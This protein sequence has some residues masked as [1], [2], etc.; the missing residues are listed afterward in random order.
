MKKTLLFL[1]II[2]CLNANAKNKFHSVNDPRIGI[3]MVVEDGIAKIKVKNLGDEELTNISIFSSSPDEVYLDAYVESLQVGEETAVIEVEISF[4]Y[5]YCALSFFAITEAET[6][7]GSFISDIS[8]DPGSFSNPNYTDFY[9]LDAPTNVYFYDFMYGWQSGEY[10]DLNNNSIVDVGDVINYTYTIYT[11]FNMGYELLTVTD[12]NASVTISGNTATGIHYITQEEINFGYVYNS[13]IGEG[14]DYCGEYQYIYFNGDVCSGC[15]N[16]NNE[17]S[18][19]PITTL[20]PHTITGNVKFNLNN[21][22]CATGINFPRRAVRALTNN[23]NYRTYTDTNGNYSINIPNINE[24][25]TITALENLSPLFTSN[26]ASRI[27]NSTANVN[28]VNY[29]NQNFCISSTTTI[30]DLSISFINTNDAIPGFVA[31]YIIF[32]HNNGTTVMNGTVSLS[33]DNSKLSFSN[34]TPSPDTVVGSSLEWNFSNLLPFETRSIPVTFSV[35]TPPTVEINDVLSFSAMVNPIASDVTPLDNTKVI[36]QTVVSSFDPNDKT[37]LEGAFIEESQANEY[38]TYLTRFQNSGTANAAFVIIKETLDANL[39]WTTFT[40][41]AESHNANIEILN[42]NELTY[43]FPNINLPYEEIEPELS[44]GWMLYK[45]KLKN[46]FTLGDIASSSSAIYFDFNQPIITNTVT[47]QFAPLSIGENNFNNF[48]I[49]PNPATNAIMISMENE[50]NAYYEIISVNG[51]KL[52]KGKVNHL[53]PIDISL[54]NSGFYF[55]N[56]SSEN[57]KMTYKLIKN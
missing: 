4:N 6:E 30:N 10:Q 1:L 54:L 39:D 50:L 27:V 20:P 16:P 12:N 19:I 13:A 26:P 17:Y 52:T 29:G 48:K 57:N 14:I 55:I 2:F 28:S 44:N 56:I 51:K 9:D 7:S 45:I 21:N 15:P 22:N 38:L 5:P 3:L 32:F 25:Y 36:N 35:F 41:I 31:N 8:A 33:F 53:K 49:T 18:I 23:F 37:V 24:S 42:G 46:N 11:D 40:P 43:S 47:T 34:A